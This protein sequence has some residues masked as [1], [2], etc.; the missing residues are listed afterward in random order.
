MVITFC[1]HR[2]IE[3]PIAVERRILDLLQQYA[4]ADVQFYLGGYGQFDR[5]ALSACQKFKSVNNG[6]RL[7]FVTP[8]LS[9]K[10]LRSVAD[11]DVYEEIIVPQRAF[12]GRY[13]II[14]R[15]RWIVDNCDF[16]IAYVQRCWGGAYKTLQ[17]ALK[18]NK[19][20]VNIASEW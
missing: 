3:D 14:R 6:A 2:E 16:V 18:V 10:Y 15:N 12:D 1:G 8:Y 11:S 4:V 5:L 7:C 9:E 17:Y 19:K 20:V 13:S